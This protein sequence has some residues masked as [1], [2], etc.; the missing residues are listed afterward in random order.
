MLQSIPVVPFSP[1]ISG[2]FF[3]IASPEDRVL[4]YPGAFDSIVKTKTMNSD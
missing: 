1:G 3:Y 2:A 4:V